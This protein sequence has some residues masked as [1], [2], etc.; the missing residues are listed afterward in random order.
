MDYKT[1]KPHADLEA[2]VSCYWS[3]QVPAS[4]QPQKQRII[5]DGKIEM[6]FIL[7]DDIKRYT[8]ETAFILQPR[9]MVLGQTMEPFYIEPTGFVDTF[10]VSFFPDGFAPFVT[11]PIKDL[12]NKE[13]PIAQL[14]AEQEAVQLE[15]QI[16]A[17][18]ATAER[19]E[20]VNHFLLKKLK[21]QSMVNSIVQS[22][23][24][25]LLS[26]KG[27]SPISTILKQN[28]S[29][30][31][32]LERKFAKQ[33]GLSPKQLG[34]LI[35]LQSALKIMLNAPEEN[36]TQIAHESAYYDQAHF[37]KDFKEFTGVSPK[38]FLGHE[39]MALSSLIYK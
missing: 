33:T 34:K 13:T 38:D 23:I 6:A 30:R 22:T 31:R 16:I 12:V 2:I 3:L 20:I 4:P 27:S 9:A 32:Q 21:K 24:E 1:Y 25:T 29:K 10:A 17:A 26:T 18:G 28:P 8:S 36:L 11:L 35:R 5:P 19:I 37:S 7:G 14:F 15:Q 39:A